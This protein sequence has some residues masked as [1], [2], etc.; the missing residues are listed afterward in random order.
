[1]GLLKNDC[2][3]P[4]EGLHASLIF[5]LSDPESA[6]SV[7]LLSQRESARVSGQLAA[8][9]LEPICAQLH[10]EGFRV[11]Q[12]ETGDQA[13]ASCECRIEAMSLIVMLALLGTND[14]GLT[15]YELQTGAGKL[16]TEERR[17]NSLHL[18]ALLPSDNDI[19][20]WNKFQS[21]ILRALDQTL[22]DRKPG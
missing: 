22:P 19:L 16:S 13:Y 20:L 12:I 5:R 15:D 21:I 9:L 2:R 17:R 3:L 14:E 18:R 11:G 1:M 6:S 4:L 7:S 8:L 10:C